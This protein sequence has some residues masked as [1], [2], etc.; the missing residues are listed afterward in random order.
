[1]AT[2]K[3][4]RPTTPILVSL[5]VAIAGFIEGESLVPENLISSRVGSFDPVSRVVPW[6]SIILRLNRGP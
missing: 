6:L 5:R 1:M 3:K 2:P 4:I